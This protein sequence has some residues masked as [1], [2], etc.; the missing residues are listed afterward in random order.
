VKTVR[1]YCASLRTWLAAAHV[2]PRGH[3]DTVQ[4]VDIDLDAMAAPPA[5]EG[6]VVEPLGDPWRTQPAVRRKPS[7]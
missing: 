1:Q 2:L 3:A 5:H 7:R 6:A 4:F